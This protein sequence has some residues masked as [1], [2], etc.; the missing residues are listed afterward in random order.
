VTSGGKN[1]APQP[2]ENLLVTSKYIEQSV[3]LGDKRK[4]CSAFIVPNLD[5]L[6]AYAEKNNISYTN[7]EDLL[8]NSAIN[9]LMRKEIDA[10]SGDLASY[11]TIKKFRL[12]KSPFTIESGELTPSLKVKRNV[13][14]QR[15]K[16][17]IDEMYQ[18]DENSI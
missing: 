5:K 16:I 9:Q 12:L 15:Y 10:V 7:E 11:E 2:I 8:K 17:L 13:V 14:E 18:E 6:K 3:V 4:Y 1:V